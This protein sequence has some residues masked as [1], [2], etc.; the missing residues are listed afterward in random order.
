M[1][2]VLWYDAP[3][4]GDW[5]RAL[6][7][8]NGRLGAMVF[9]NVSGERIAL[10]E[11]TI[12]QR[13]AR[14]RINPTAERHLPIIRRMLVDGLPGEAEYLAESTMMGQPS[15]VHPY[16]P[17]GD[18]RLTFA[19]TYAH[20]GARRVRLTEPRG[21]RRDLNLREAVARV[22]Y[23]LGETRFHREVFCSA[24]DDVV[25]V[26]LSGDTQR[27]VNATVELRR[28]FDADAAREGDAGLRLTGR[29]GA[30]GTR[31][32]ARLLAV[33]EGGEV[34]ANGVCIRIEG[35]HAV[36]LLI[37]CG[38]DYA[39]G[40][41][42]TL[43]SAALSRVAST[44][45]RRLREDHM[46]AHAALFDRVSLE[47]EGRQGSFASRGSG[48]ATGSGAAEPTSRGAEADPTDRRLARV[49]EGGGDPALA[50]TYFQFG[51]Y[52]MICGSRASALPLNLQ[53]I[54]NASF[55]PAWSCDFH[56]NIN[57]QM[58]YWPAEVAN[59]SECHDP[60]FNWMRDT[61]APAGREV[62]RR[63]YGCRGWVAHHLSDP[64]GFAVPGDSA[65]CGLWP[66]GGAWLCTHL[67]ER[68]LFTS[69]RGFLREAAFPLMRE[70]CEFFLDYLYRDTGG[71]LVTGPSVSP[72]NR[73]RLPSGAE[74]KLC[75]APTMDS[76]ILR[77]LFGQT[78]EAAAELGLEGDEVADAIRHALPQLPANR[79][80]SD[81]R[82]L[83]WAEEYDEPEPGHRHV[84]HLWGLF[85]GHQINP[86][87]TPALTDACRRTLEARLGRGGGHTGWS[88]AWLSCLFAR[89]RDADAAHAAITK[90][91]SES[92]LPNLFD[93]HP[94]FQ[95]DGNFGGCAAIAEML[96]QSRFEPSSGWVELHLL[97]ALP[98][99]WP[100]GRFRGLRARGG[101]TVDAAWRDGVLTAAIIRAEAPRAV[102]LYVA[103]CSD[104]RELQLE[105]GVGVDV[106]PTRT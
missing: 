43:A 26:R 76:Q 14:G 62:A 64:W 3:A 13:S 52:L 38:T 55:T 84:S 4:G 32:E 19:D 66:A 87:R 73:Y 94:P 85:P 60:L 2:H 99:R 90:L 28:L 17:L 11:E 75:M 36:T 103:G 47:F 69:D 80:G 78:L 67:W 96:L 57:L 40:E 79:V 77:E 50:A 82:L 93:N 102:R 65:N 48:H 63:H 100:A 58:N 44:P 29:A 51:R 91:F 9:G 74:G 37:T 5:N 25:V 61:L 16:Q 105:P 12:W 6:P 70:A 18:L 10:N 35:C 21:Y 49:G 15:R 68:F 34:V 86:D 56:L 33:P 30:E 7:V 59:L 31:F 53:G 39:G 1:K 8:G 71:R 106:T 20:R 41:P 81:G 101:V 97:P 83:E 88:A 23:Q 98:E 45:Y 27:C 42:A 104:V 72:E 24:A 54:W 95:I 89:L 46:T 22:S 92:T